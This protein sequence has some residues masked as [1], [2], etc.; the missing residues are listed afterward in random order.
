[1]SEL[2]WLASTNPAERMAYLEHVATDRKLRLFTSA[3][4]R[5]SWEKLRDERSKRAIL[6]GELYADG[7]INNATLEVALNGAALALQDIQRV[8]RR[9]KREL[10]IARTL[11][12]LICARLPSWPTQ[13]AIT[14]AAAI[15][16][17]RRQANDNVTEVVSW[18]DDIFG[19]PFRP[20]V[21]E[22]AW[23]SSTAVGLARG[24]YDDRAFD[25]LP[26]LADALQ[27]AGCENA[28]ILDHC[29]GDG[30]HVRGCWVVDLVLGKA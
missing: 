11:D 20:V 18:T 28:D 12:A 16:T 22:P 24:I 3:C 10:S 25:R 14:F 7:Q 6:A 4:A 27:D 13:S 9:S 2:E 1:M 23:L 19:N 15:D 26:I 29:R 8:F 17:I 30:P 5:W 21:I